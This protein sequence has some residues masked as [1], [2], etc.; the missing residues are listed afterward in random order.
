MAEKRGIARPYAEAVFDLAREGDQLVGWSEALHAAAEVVRNKDLA[1]LIDTPRTDIGAL[2]ALITG[3][4]EE[5]SSG[6][7]VGLAQV[8]NLLQLLAENRRL[9]ALPDIAEI[10]DKLKADVENSVDVVLV[11]ASPVNSLQQKK[12][13]AALKKRFGREVNLRFEL[14]ENLIGGARL[15][16]EDLIIDGS[17]RTGLEKLSN[18][19]TN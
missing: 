13:T 18:T 17:V 14:D 9:L 12:I 5:V 1:R 15:Q 6:R 7:R 16:A 11:A 8:S 3:V 4:C 19:L 2:V 10:F